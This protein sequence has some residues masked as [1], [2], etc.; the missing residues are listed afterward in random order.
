MSYYVAMNNQQQGPFEVEQL[1]TMNLSPHTLVWREGMADWVPASKVADLHFLFAPPPPPPNPVGPP[2][3][4][5]PGQ[6]VQ[7]APGYVAP[8]FNKSEVN[9]KKVLTGILALFLGGLGIHK[10]VLGL[11]SAAVAMLLISTL[12]S[13]F[14][15]GI[16]WMV[17]HV[18]GI[19]EGIIYLTKSD[20]QFYQDYYVSRRGWF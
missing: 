14:S 17:M 1:R 8:G 11:T 9:G 16:S 20:E 19:V 12:G 13:C 5:Y 7:Y 15:Y 3:A 18:I 4:G 10:F 2:V 6:V